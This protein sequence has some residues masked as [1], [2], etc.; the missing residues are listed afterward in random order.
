MTTKDD[1]RSSSKNS[2]EDGAIAQTQ[3]RSPGEAALIG[4]FILLFVSVLKY[5]SAILIPLTLSILLSLLFAPVVHFLTLIHIPKRIG[6]ALVVTVLLALIVGGIAILS[7][8][9]D[10]WL[11][12]SPRIFQRID[13]KL[14]KIKEPIKQVQ[15]AAKKVEDL[16]DMDEEQGAIEVK[17]QT[18]RL[19]EKIF[20][21]TPSFLAFLL[22]SIVL[23]YF[24]LFSGKSLAK[25]LIQAIFWF[26]GQT[27]DDDMGHHIQQEIS[28]YL[29][30]I[31]IINGCLG[32]MTATVLVLIGLPNAI[33]WGTMA[34]LLNFAPYIGAV[35]SAVIISL[36]S[37]V[38]FDSFP[39]ILIAPAAFLF[40]TTL[41]GQFI[42]PQVL[43]SQFAMN[44]LIV[45]LSIILWGWLWGYI[46]ALL[47]F[48]LL[49]ITK[50]ISQSLDA[51][52]PIALF[53]E[54]PRTNDNH[55]G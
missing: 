31:T 32:I 50:I 14:Q 45:F 28:R 8:P 33:L 39:Y 49:V 27:A 17:P 24:L 3:R 11:D 2:P 4:I 20:L 5:A 55:R 25:H 47:A 23:L 53:L 1:S 40:I 6:A 42:T 51:L 41:E 44:P 43:G 13:K 15:E 36:V 7:E 22:L 52:Q 9:A 48:P 37:F 30:T 35:C 29:L 26:A 16:T 54:D 34:G 19:D 21:A 12:K 10:E 46:G 18:K 38:T